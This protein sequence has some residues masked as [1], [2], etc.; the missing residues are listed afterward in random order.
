MADLHNKLAL[1]RKGISG[2]KENAVASA[3]ESPPN[4][5]DRI[6]AMIPPPPHPQAN[7]SNTEASE[8]DDWD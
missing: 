2:T 8:D 6:S 3:V 7:S 1:R 4:V 5:M